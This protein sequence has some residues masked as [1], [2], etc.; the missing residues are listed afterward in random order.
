M[1]PGEEVEVGKL[2]VQK[3][4]LQTSIC[5]V[6]SAEAPIEVGQRVAYEGHLQTVKRWMPK[7]LQRLF[8]R[9]AREEVPQ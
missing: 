8:Q 2:R 5:K 6:G 7:S 1:L 4:S 3:V 9:R